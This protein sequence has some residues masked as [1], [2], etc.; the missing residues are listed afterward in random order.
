MGQRHASQL[1]PAVGRTMTRW[2]SWRVIAG[3]AIL[4]AAQACRAAAA[5][6]LTELSLE[7][8]LQVELPPLSASTV[9]V[10][11]AT[12]VDSCIVTA[13]DHAFGTYDP[14]VPTPTDAA[15]SIRVTCTVDAVY[16][17]GLSAGAGMGATVAA[18]RMTRDDQALTY[19]LYRDPAR[20]LVWG[21]R[22]GTDTVSGTGTGAP[23]N[24]LVFGRIG[25]RQMVRKGLYVDTVVATVFY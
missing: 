10:V 18:R 24:H 19:S 21:D 1:Q 9:F 25:A 23:T 12:A 20:T 15:S 6:D 8:L 11:S 3:A 2:V 22:V 5:A 13:S 14:L 4:A 17:I 7:A 16:H